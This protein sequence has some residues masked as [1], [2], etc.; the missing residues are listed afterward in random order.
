ML[1]CGL[2]ATLSGWTDAPDNAIQITHSLS[3]I[4]KLDGETCGRNREAIPGTDC[5]TRTIHIIQGVWANIFTSRNLRAIPSRVAHEYKHFTIVHSS[6]AT[7]ELYGS[8]RSPISPTFWL[9]RREL[10]LRGATR[11]GCTKLTSRIRFW[12]SVMVTFHYSHNQTY[13]AAKT[14]L[15]LS[16]K[17]SS[18]NPRSSFAQ[19]SSLSAWPAPSAHWY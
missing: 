18:F 17:S 3:N 5:H 6:A 8:F 14:A 1:W 7:G 15:T 10:R 16:L 9:L 12:S 4:R 13:M 2:R 11:S 19:S